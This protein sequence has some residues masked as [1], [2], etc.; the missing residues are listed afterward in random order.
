MKVYASAGGVCVERSVAGDYHPIVGCAD[1]G[2]IQKVEHTILNNGVSH[3][4][5]FDVDS[6]DVTIG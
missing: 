4:V 1:D 2:V 3:G 6:V 5:C